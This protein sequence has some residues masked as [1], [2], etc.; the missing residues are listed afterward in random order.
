MNTMK[1][2]LVEYTGPGKLGPTQV[3]A[4]VRG[5]NPD[6]ALN[7]ALAGHHWGGPLTQLDIDYAKVTPRKKRTPQ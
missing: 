5:R 7:R 1:S 4:N 2:Y 6:D 3:H